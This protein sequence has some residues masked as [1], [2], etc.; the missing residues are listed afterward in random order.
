M[1]S[2]TR[3]LG[4][5][6]RWINGSWFAFNYVRSHT[7]IRTSFLFLIQIIFYLVVQGLAWIGP[8]LFFIAMNLTLVAAVREY[9]VPIALN[10]FLSEADYELSNYRIGIF[11]MKN[12]IESIPDIFNFVFLILIFAVIVHSL[13]INHNNKSFKK[14]YYMASTVFGVYGIIVI[15]LLIY[16]TYEIIFHFERQD[17]SEKEFLIPVTFLRSVIIFIIIGHSLPILWS[18]NPIKYVECITSIFP[19]IYYVPTYVNI[20]Q[21][22][23]F[24]RI[25]D[26]SWG[27]KG[28]DDD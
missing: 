5:R 11:N 3:L 21:I 27:T 2:L 12:V 16:N 1:T 8:A 14:I 13:L 26:M 28:L 4:Q 19:Y 20:L 22:F 17:E 7:H 25:N 10:F 9:I 15:I 24:C 6:R 18:L 23:A